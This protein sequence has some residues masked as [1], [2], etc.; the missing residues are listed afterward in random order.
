MIINDVKS[1][2]KAIN[3]LNTKPQY[4]A[5]PSLKS[6]NDNVHVSSSGVVH[7]GKTASIGAAPAVPITTG[8]TVSQGVDSGSYSDIAPSSGKSYQDQILDY[9]AIEAQKERDWAEYMSNT[10][11]QREVADLKAAGLN[12]ILSANQGANGY[13]GAAASSG[14]S[15]KLALRLAKIQAANNINTAQIAAGSAQNVA[16]IQALSNANVAAMNN[17]NAQEVAKINANAQTNRGWLD[18]LGNG[19]RALAYIR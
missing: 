10:S 2:I 5:I 19:I 18:V 8:K 11:H 6:T 1:A 17:N 16:T 9:N 13:T 14:T 12:P 4:I 3:T 7:S 15:E